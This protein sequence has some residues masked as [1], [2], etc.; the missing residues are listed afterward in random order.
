MTIHFAAAE[1]APLEQPRETA[2][3]PPVAEAGDPPQRPLVGEEGQEEPV[4]VGERV[5]ARQLGAGKMHYWRFSSCEMR[6]R[7]PLTNAGD[8]AAP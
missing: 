5:E 1:L 4:H 3:E 8:S 6:S 7:M 2:R